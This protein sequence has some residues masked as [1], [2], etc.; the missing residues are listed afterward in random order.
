VGYTDDSDRNVMTALGRRL[1]RPQLAEP[2]FRRRVS[3]PSAA[4]L[5]I[6]LL[7]SVSAHAQQ[8]GVAA[9]REAA[10]KAFAAGKYEEAASL[11]EVFA[12]DESMIVLR[13]QT[14]IVR[15]D[16][17]R[18]LTLLQPVVVENPGGEA[19]LELGLLQRYLGRRGEA[20]RTL[21]LLRLAQGPGTA[22]RAFV[23]AGRAARAVSSFEE[24]NAL[25]REAVTD[26]PND[27][28]A[29]TAWGELF[30][31]KHERAEAVKSFQAALKVSAE[32]QPALLG[33][34]RTMTEDNPP[35][36]TRLARHVLEL[37]PSNPDAHLILAELAIDEDRLVDAA[38]HIERAKS[39]NPNSLEALALGAA[40]AFVE[41]RDDAYQANV[42][43]ALKINPLYGELHRVTG[44]ITARFY[45][46]DEAAEQARK[47]TLLDRENARAH[48][49]LG[50]HLM[51]T[52]DERNA[53]RALD[54][55]FRADPYDKVTYN[56]LDLLDKLEAFETVREGDL[57]I[58]L[59]RD[60]VGVMREYAPALA[61]EALS[62]L[63]ERWG[64]TP[65]GPILIEIFPVHDDFA[66]RNVGL[67]GMIGALG[68]CFGRVVTMDS[69]K[70]RPPGEFNWGATLWHELAHVITLQL[71]NQRIPRWL[72]EGISVF[73]ETRAERNWGREMEVPFARAID[74]GKVL[75]LKDLNAGFQ[76][77]RTISLAYYEASLLVEHIVAQHGDATLKALVQSFA[78]GITTDQAVQ[79]VL[80][81][82]LDAMQTS[83]DAFL[84][85]RFDGLRKALATP[86]EW[87]PDLPVDK[88]KALA[89]S[90]PDSYAVQAALG[91]ALQS[92]DP[93]AAFQ[94]F[95]RA[96]T[97]V[98]MAT[99]AESPY[100]L[101][102]QLALKKGDRARAAK[103]L[104]AWTLR[105][106]TDIEA[107]RQLSTLLD[108]PADRDRLK[109]ALRRV[110]AIDP[111][112]SAAHSTLGRM[113]L[114]A[115]EAPEAIRDFRVALAAGP[116]D[117]ASA[118]ADLAEGL[119][120]TGARDE[121]K[122][123]TLAALEIAPTYE[124]A[125]DL[126]LKLVEGGEPR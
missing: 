54:Q 10:Q 103:V 77:P 118:H 32:Y 123:Q 79:R 39:I 95:E 38:D 88:L 59:H 100:G 11:T 44:A 48:A 90:H 55:A 61:R 83:F 122:R 85:Q 22:S 45:R 96:T 17:E 12:K 66:V 106:H 51:R 60:E 1:S 9:A 110:V 125:Q 47:A 97:L 89:A 49:D 64:F 24:A 19:A 3:C 4:L 73:E 13:A 116:L 68:A 70:A 87:Q 15:G 52:G 72:T 126:L 21:Q 117:R 16:Y 105:D 71:S 107:A 120:V 82:D 101:M 53:R 112:D 99:G 50:A 108:Q 36:A 20:R 2:S 28:A 67:P 98:P 42:A 56:L 40:L 14:F 58:K 113:A 102:V 104:E 46:F 119:W 121:A 23:R 5:V 93:D 81:T 26:T 29:N 8:P 69:P 31:E 78:E 30:L 35:A 63:T 75:K 84:A 65:K 74:E 80:K 86:D 124:R 114:D 94:A 41:G 18:A 34:A 57:I 6:V 33:L 37:N 43:A 62:S 111:F 7:S 25:F 91:H 76:D 115:G 92:T 27:P 109:V